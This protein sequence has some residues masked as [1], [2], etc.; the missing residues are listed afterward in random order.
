MEVHAMTNAG[1]WIQRLSEEGIGIAVDV[2]EQAL[3]SDTWRG[4]TVNELTKHILTRKETFLDRRRPAQVQVDKEDMMRALLCSFKR[5]LDRK[6]ISRR[7]LHA[8][9]RT[10]F[11][12]YAN[13]MQDRES[14]DAV[15]EFAR[16]HDGQRPPGF[17]TVSPSRACN[18]RCTG[19]YASAGPGAEG[20]HWEELSRIVTDAKRQWGVRFFVISGGEP[21]AYRSQGKSLLD[22]IK[23]H[24]DCFFMAYTNGTLIDARAAE[25]LAETGNLTPAISVEGFEERTD[26]RRGAGVFQ[27]V[28]TAMGHLRRVG[29]PFGISLT[30]TRDNAEEILSDQF[31]DFFFDEQ[32]A[33]YGWLFQYM[34]IGRAYTLDLLITP[35]QRLWMWRR[36]WQLVRERHI[37][38]ADFWN[39]GTVS[40]GCI[41]AGAPGGYLYIDW[42]G[43]VMP[44][45]F[46]PYAAANIHDIYRR[47]GTLDDIYELPYFR[48]IR[49]WQF[50]YGL[51]KE[52]AEEHGNW[53][54]PCSFRDHYGMGR[55]LID[56]FHPEPED[57]TAAQ[58]LQDHDYSD[59][60]IRYDKA[61]EE[62]FEPVWEE[63]YLHESSVPATV[64][65]DPRGCP[66]AHQ[67]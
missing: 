25:R 13:E 56:T 31:I 39:C 5:A 49:R 28:L 59:G 20:L 7:V 34:P 43:K 23:A 22:L 54:L 8:L 18:L 30:A 67:L 42:N 16:R 53:L 2:L 15:V 60:L 40:E 33:V 36:T 21:F 51:G 12:N 26:E 66:A 19:C 58:A 38:L 10:A 1:G 27:R 61:L 9:L 17:I 52:R 44:C 57:A 62:L 32:Q 24:H 63:E 65:E 4:V 6:Q 45:V 14:K 55:E 35:E 41:A 37:M 11:G 50:D 48:A 3:L 64:H 46:V 29:V 47:G